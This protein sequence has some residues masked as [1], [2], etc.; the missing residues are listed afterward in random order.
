MIFS[1]YS[2]NTEEPLSGLALARQ[3]GHPSAAITAGGSLLEMAHQAALPVIVLPLGLPPRLAV[4]YSFL[5]IARLCLGVKKVKEIKANMPEIEAGVKN[6][7]EVG[8]KLADSI[9]DRPVIVYAST[10]N[11]PLAYYWK[12]TFNET[13]KR[14]AFW[15]VLPEQ[16][17]NELESPSSDTHYLLLR[18]A[19]DK[20][21]IAK[22][23]D[24]IV[25]QYEGLGLRVDSVELP[26]GSPLERIFYA[27]SLANWVAY[28]VAARSGK[29]PASVPIIEGFKKSLRNEN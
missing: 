26:N 15:N 4:G 3:M 20:P 24:I 25:K 2:G 29:D 21:Q 13:G 28:H 7:E 14:A 22:R 8:K 10:S 11:Q 1:S 5:A 19:S 16:N 17:H 12:I 23:F 9:S 18:D 27:V 6:L